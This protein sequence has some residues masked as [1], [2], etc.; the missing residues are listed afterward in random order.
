MSNTDMSVPRTYLIAKISIIAYEKYRP[1]SI[2]NTN[3]VLLYENF[4][5]LL[6]FL[7]LHNCRLEGYIP[8][9]LIVVG[10]FTMLQIVIFMVMHHRIRRT[11]DE[12]D[13][14]YAVLLCCTSI[15]VPFLFTWF[16]AGNIT[17]DYTKQNF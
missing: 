12:E 16:V 14:C 6:G 17:F 3:Q 10:I 13:T 1:C 4:A 8:I 15:I 11:G 9:Y 7:Y 2:N 5:Y